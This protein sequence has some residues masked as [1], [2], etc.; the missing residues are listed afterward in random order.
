MVRQFVKRHLSK[1]DNLLGHG[2]IIFLGSV[3]VNILNYVYQLL[4][5][6]LL[7]PADFAVLGALFALIYIVTFSFG[8]VRTVVMKY[9]ADYF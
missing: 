1:D 9:S 6:R 2:L 8:A 3:V 4:M 5:G 7:G